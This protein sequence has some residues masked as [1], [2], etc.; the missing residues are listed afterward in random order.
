VGTVDVT[1]AVNPQV[2]VPVT[3]PQDTSG[4]LPSLPQTGF[5]VAKYAAGSVLLIGL[6]T[7]LVVLVR[8]RRA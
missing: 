2:T 8:R 4:C 1:F 6:G 5:E 7:T 3:F